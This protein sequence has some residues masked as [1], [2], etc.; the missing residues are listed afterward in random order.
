MKIFFSALHMSNLWAV[1]FFFF[2]METKTSLL[3]RTL[4]TRDLYKENDKE[5]IERGSGDTLGHLN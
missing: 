3:I 4:S 1:L 2:E 5:E